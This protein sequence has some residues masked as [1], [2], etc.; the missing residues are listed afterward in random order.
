MTNFYMVSIV[1]VLFLFYFSV[2]PIQVY[3][4]YSETGEMFRVI[5][6]NS[7]YKTD[8]DFLSVVPKFTVTFVQWIATAMNI[9]ELLENREIIKASSSSQHQKPSEQDSS[10][11]VD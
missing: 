8:R 10:N 2:D 1:I 4:L 5:Y 11:L 6:L 3:K 7:A 9:L